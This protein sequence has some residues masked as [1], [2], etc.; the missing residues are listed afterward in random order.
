M[1]KKRGIKK[2]NQY[3]DKLRKRENKIR[4]SGNVVSMKKEDIIRAMDSHGFT[5]YRI[6]PW[7]SI[8]LQSKFDYWIIESDGSVVYLKHG[9]EKLL[10]VGNE[11][12]SYHL[13]NVFYDLDFCIKSIKE[14]DEFKSR[15]V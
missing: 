9:N 15:R 4:N 14:H 5:N 7:G 3:H 13:H 11:R 8:N 6:N 1:A 12:S 2:R 10:R